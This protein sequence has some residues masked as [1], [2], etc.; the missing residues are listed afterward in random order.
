MSLKYCQLCV[1]F[2]AMSL[3][4]AGAVFSAAIGGGEPAPGED[5]KDGNAGADPAK[6]ANAPPA[7]AGNDVFG[8]PLPTSCRARLGTVRLRHNGD[9][10]FVAFSEDGARIAVA[11]ATGLGIWETATGN[12]LTSIPPDARADGVAFSS[13]GKQVV[14][15]CAHPIRI[16]HWDLA[17][18]RPMGESAG[19]ASFSGHLVRISSDRTHAVV[20]SS[21]S[22]ECCAWDMSKG[23]WLLSFGN[24]KDQGTVAAV[25][26]HGD[27]FATGSGKGAVR[28]WDAAGKERQA[29]NMKEGEIDD[30]QFSPN[31]SLLAC[32]AGVDFPMNGGHPVKGVQSPWEVHDGA[33]AAQL[34]P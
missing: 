34:H 8:V 4:G 18:G 2:M 12:P 27:A 31:D 5:P 7:P 23:K 10:D 9:A 21:T 16:Q 24:E 15:V 25:S 28:F 30:L 32:S 3:F 29:W 17:T 13:D 22:G 19:D 14:T 20:A 1:A 11:S 26:Q 33:K 6:R